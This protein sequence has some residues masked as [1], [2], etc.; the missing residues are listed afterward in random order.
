[1]KLELADSLTGIVDEERTLELPVKWITEEEA[2][3]NY[4]QRG[5]GGDFHLTQVA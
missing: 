2:L 4:L 1:M 5:Y 3:A